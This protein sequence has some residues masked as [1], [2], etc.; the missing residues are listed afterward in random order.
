MTDRLGLNIHAP[1]GADLPRLLDR[2]IESGAR[3]VRVDFVWAAI[4]PEPLVERW[5]P[6]DAI[7]AAAEARGLKV[8][9]IL[10]Y[11]PTWVAPTDLT[12][13]VWERFCWRIATRYAGRVFAWEL[14]NEPNLLRWGGS[15]RD[16]VDL[17]LPG[18]V[19]IRA[20]D[21]AALVGGPGLAH[22]RRRAWGRWL[23]EVLRAGVRLD[24]ISHHCYASTP[25]KLTKKLAGRTILGRWPALWRLIEPSL[26]EV[27]RREVT[28]PVW[29]TEYGWASNRTGERRQA[30]YLAS[31]RPPPWIERAFVYEIQ[32]DPRIA[33]KWG[34]LRADGSRKPA[35]AALAETTQ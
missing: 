18:A 22:I 25:E 7:V 34:L 6:Y 17:I 24:F 3:W 10:A 9:G 20:A 35:L 12:E 33:E 21:P 2:V 8:L 11:A 15:A 26:R 1:Q 27:L 4:E 31:W 28:P 30:D 13:L 14:W 5:E 32:D 23:I 29:L 16:Y 19:S